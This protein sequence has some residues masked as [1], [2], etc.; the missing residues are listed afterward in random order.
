MT[1]SERLF[2]DAVFIGVLA[3]FSAAFLRI[4][5]PFILNAFLAIVLANM[6][7]RPFLAVAERTG[8]DLA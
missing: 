3:I 2:L 5:Q 7:R 4:M 1:R 6:F 8:R